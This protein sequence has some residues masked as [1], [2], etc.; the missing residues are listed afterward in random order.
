MWLAMVWALT[1]KDMPPMCL[2]PAA[3]CNGAFK[4]TDFKFCAM[5]F[6]PVIG[7]CL[8]YDK[9][10]EMFARVT[11]YKMK[12]GSKDATTAT[13]AESEIMGMPDHNFLINVLNDDGSGYVSYLGGRKRRRQTQ[14][15]SESG[16]A[17]GAFSDHMEAALIVLLAVTSLNWANQIS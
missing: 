13:A 3:K 12:P 16:R 14:M 15:P 9:G 10:F 6:R 7:L 11:H 5:N 17:L 2:A 1:S 4:S 8:F